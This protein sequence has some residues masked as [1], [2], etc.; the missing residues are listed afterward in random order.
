MM[1][2]VSGGESCIR[3]YGWISN[4]SLRFHVRTYPYGQHPRAK[5]KQQYLFA[6]A[7]ARVY[8]ASR[9]MTQRDWDR[10]LLDE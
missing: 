7:S 3:A 10:V 5:N 2:G 1:V 9:M 4:A 8:P 6:V